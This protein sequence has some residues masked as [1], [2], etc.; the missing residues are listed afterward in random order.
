MCHGFQRV[1]LQHPSCFAWG[2]ETL[3]GNRSLRV[4]LALVYRGRDWRCSLSDS[5]HGFLLAHRVSWVS[6]IAD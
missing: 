5:L 3:A 6:K 1:W 2:R 4:P